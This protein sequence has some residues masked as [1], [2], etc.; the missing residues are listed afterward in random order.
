MFKQEIDVI[1]HITG[2]FKKCAMP[3]Y[4]W[5]KNNNTLHING[6]EF[7]SNAHINEHSWILWAKFWWSLVWSFENR[8][9]CSLVQ[10][11]PPQ[12]PSSL[13]LKCCYE[14]LNPLKV[15]SGRKVCVLF[16]QAYTCIM[17]VFLRLRYGNAQKYTHKTWWK[18]ESF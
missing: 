10:L 14:P 4:F 11:G 12:R 8:S 7:S 6:W 1:N 13:K 5:M 18:K 15:P 17:T 9:M 2:T 16:L 3:F